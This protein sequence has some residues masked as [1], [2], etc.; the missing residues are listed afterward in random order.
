[1]MR[2]FFLILILMLTGCSMDWPDKFAGDYECTVDKDC[3]EGF[4]C[5]LVLGVCAEI[6]S[7][8][9][10]SH[11]VGDSCFENDNVETC[12][13]GST[14]QDCNADAPSGSVA[15]CVPTQNDPSI[16]ECSFQCDDGFVVIDFECVE[17]SAGCPDGQHESDGE[18]Y[19]NDLVDHCW[20]GSTSLNCMDTVPDNSTATCSL[21]EETG[22]YGCLYNCFDEFV[23]DSETLDCVCPEGEHE[24]DDVCYANN[25]L[26]H[27]WN[28]ET[29]LDCTSSTPMNA[30]A[31]CDGSDDNG[32]FSC[33]FEC[34]PNFVLNSEDLCDPVVSC[35]DGQHDMGNVC[36]DY[37]DVEH[38]WDGENSLNCTTNVPENASAVCLAVG[39]EFDP[40][41]TCSF[42][43]LEDY[44]DVNGTCFPLPTDMT[45]VPAGLFY[46]GCAP[47]D[48]Q[49]DSRESP[50]HDV[51]LDAYLID[52][53]EVT[54]EDYKQCVDAE[55]CEYE[56]STSG[57]LRTYDRSG[58]ADH[59]INNVN[60]NEA[61]TYCEWKGKSLPTEA[62]WEKAARG[63]TGL[64][65]PWGDAPTAPAACDYGAMNGCDVKTQPVGTYPLGVSP[66]GAYDM[67]GNV[68]EWVSDW[69]H[70]DYYQS[71]DDGWS[72]PIGPDSGVDNA[73]VVK[74]G[75][76]S[77]GDSANDANI[78]RASKRGFSGKNSRENYYGFRCA[79]AVN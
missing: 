61:S 55:V 2:N 76:F 65:Y 9:D 37:N 31:S 24:F 58:Y 23:V 7:C 47:T 71:Q 25:D 22:N 33:N 50:A 18:C 1:M 6:M 49:C 35:P 62:E 63:D 27:C 43:C 10:N 75:A 21:N 5:D 4:S 60:H 19:N 77:L 26:E 44:Y 34:D 51:Y 3:L 36:Y 54:A 59:P 48:A 66:Y 72:N 69:Y 68:Y 79:K 14:G 52:I 45:F 42:Q 57:N 30:T 17:E 20:D 41:F 8:P 13:D 40:A 64:I 39:D 74:G 56:G 53:H 67:S 29:S 46:M 70:P 38:C 11:R 32:Y 12:W 28:G 15:S 78:W 16:Y 73:R